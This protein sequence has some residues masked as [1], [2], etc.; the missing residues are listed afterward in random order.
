MLVDKLY[1]YVRLWERKI[2]FSD[3][4]ATFQQAAKE[5]GTY[6][7]SGLTPAS[8]FS[9]FVIVQEGQS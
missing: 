3:P 2:S 1:K 6:Q 4:A 8:D 7:S 9:T 5:A